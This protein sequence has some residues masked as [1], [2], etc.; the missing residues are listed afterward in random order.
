MKAAPKQ[1]EEEC[2]VFPMKQILEPA[3]A[4]PKAGLDQVVRVI[5]APPLVAGALLLLLHQ[6]GY[7]PGASLWVGL[8]CLSMLPLL[9]YPVWLFVPH[10]LVGGRHSQRKTAVVFSVLGYLVGAAYCLFGNVGR[11]ELTV[12]LTYL[13]S[14]SLIAF[15]SKVLKFPISGHACGV[16]GPIAVL[17]YARGALWLLGLL[18]LAAVFWSSLRMKRHTLPQLLCGGASSVLS[19]LF[20]LAVL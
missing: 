15:C 3:S 14:G 4:K 13:L 1:Y 5:T 17:I 16:M 10:L 19:M 18:V 12:F 7:F 6:A 2:V 9:A 11:L 8:L 20:W